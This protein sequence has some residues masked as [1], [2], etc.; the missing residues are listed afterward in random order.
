MFNT[1]AD[2]EGAYRFFRNE[3][4]DWGKVLAPHLAVTGGRSDACEKVLMLHDTTDFC[5]SGEQR[6]EGLGFVVHEYSQGFLGHFALAVS[7]DSP[8]VPLGILG[9]ETYVREGKPKRTKYSRNATDKESFRW[10]RLVAAVKDRLNPKTEV[11]HVMDSEA[12]NYQLLD[13]LAALNQRFVIRLCHDR[14]LRENTRTTLTEKL[15]GLSSVCERE[16]QLSARTKTDKNSKRNPP[17]K[18]RLARLSFT[19]TSIEIGVPDRVKATAK[20]LR[21]NVVHV[22]ELNPPTTEEKVEWRLLTTEPIETEEQILE[23]V[24]MYRGRWVIEEFFKVLKTGCKYEER[25]LESYKTLL[26]ALALFIP[27]A[28]RLLLLRSLS[29][30]SED[31]PPSLVLSKVQVTLLKLL[32]ETKLKESSS[33]KEAL[34]AIARL[35]GH[36]KN[37]GDPGWL[38]LWR[39]FKKLR[40]AEVGWNLKK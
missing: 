31:L 36:I 20:S 2:L 3:N 28:H 15:S 30:S 5:F 10:I 13:G 24:D 33:L 6:R 22:E 4:V 32:P 1:E 9:V 16:V 35:G 18:K 34:H 7:V 27:V 12:D 19:A 39:G 17:R 26:T 11:I 8:Q 21:F 14:I 37:N 40:M 29:R 25:Q 23:I 38:T